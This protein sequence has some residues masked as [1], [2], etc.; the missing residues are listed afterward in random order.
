MQANVLF[1]L[2]VPLEFIGPCRTNIDNLKNVVTLVKICLTLK[3][4]GSEI[5]TL[6][7]IRQKKATR[8]L[9]NFYILL[10]TIKTTYK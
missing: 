3:Y 1:T 4:L 7:I 10:Q 2:V 6:I 8:A 9:S 5:A